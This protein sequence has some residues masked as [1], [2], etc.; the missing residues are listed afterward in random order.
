[1]TNNKRWYTIVLA[2]CLIMVLLPSP[3]GFWPGLVVSMVQ[4]WACL[5]VLSAIA[6]WERKK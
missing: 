6:P 3:D 5:A 4:Y 1:M 2:S